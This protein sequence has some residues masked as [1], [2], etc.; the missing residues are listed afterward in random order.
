MDSV[1]GAHRMK[2]MRFFLAAIIISF[3]S[4]TFASA[5]GSFQDQSAQKFGVAQVMQILEERPE[6]SMG[7]KRTVQKVEMKIVSGVDA[8][9]SWIVETSFLEGKEE[10]RLSV[11]QKMIVEK[12]TK[13]NG[14]TQYLMREPYRL[15]GILWIGAFFL[16]LV[17]LFGRFTGLMSMVGLALS[18]AVLLL[19][20]VPKIAAGHD[21]L[22]ICFLS[23]V[24]IACT[25]LYLAHG[26][27]FRTTIALVSTLITLVISVIIAIVFVNVVHI[28][29]MGTEEAM[30][31]QMGLLDNVNLKG[32]LL[33]GMIIGAL[34][35]LDDVTTAQTAAIA[36]IAHANPKLSFTE[37]YKRGSNVGRE[38]IA[39]LINTLA[40]AYAGASFPLLL[41]FHANS[42]WP[43]WVTL[44]SEFLAEEI[45][46]TLVGSATL[47]FAVPI[48][49]WIAAWAFQGGRN[50]DA[51]K[52]MH[53]HSH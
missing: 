26:F 17:V 40:L 21:P 44:N 33:G 46:R 5:Q 51:R 25:S 29:G 2:I 42:T 1:P 7:I 52:S 11:N 30:Y 3:S 50:T 49:T 37:L 13:S 39:S 31:L 36:E 45:V 24:G 47:L 23:A 6:D 38:H 12:Q 19:F 8:G 48:S 27:R 16:L 4:V 15:P 53:G 9:E 18:A 35:V 28:F 41:L 22:L 32:L 20:A 14:E 43:F 10:M 34:G